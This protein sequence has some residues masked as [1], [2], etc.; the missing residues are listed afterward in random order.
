MKVGHFSDAHFEFRA[1]H[2]KLFKGNPEGDV[3][4]VAGDLWTAPFA[5]KGRNDAD[6]RSVLKAIKKLQQNVFSKFTSVLYVMGNH[7]HYRFKFDCTV[8]VIKEFFEGTNVKVLDNDFVKIHDVVFIG[9]TLW[10]DFMKASPIAM[11]T[12]RGGMNDF[13]II[14]TGDPAKWPPKAWHNWEYAPRDQI[15]APSNALDEHLMSKRYIEFVAKQHRDDKVV[16]VSHHG[17]TYKSL[18]KKHVGNGLDGAYCSD[19]SD[20]ILGNHNI[21]HWVHGHTHMSVDYMVGDCRILANQVG[22]FGEHCY[23]DFDGIQFF[24]V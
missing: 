2:P 23:S 10:S 3:L 20:F 21:R 15:F 12:C 5:V 1:P 13:K 17:P 18:S 4:I 8:P 9:C 24:E 6:A 22:Y 7:E 16:V 19:M 14:A 11:E